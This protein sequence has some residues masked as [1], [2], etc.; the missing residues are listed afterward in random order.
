MRMRVECGSVKWEGE[1]ESATEAIKRA[2]VELPEHSS[3]LLR[4][5][6]GHGWKYLA[7]HVGLKIAGYSLI[8]TDDGH[9][10][11]KT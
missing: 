2:L 1:A 5:N 7:F 9:E 6:D 3:P 11:V 8:P 10:L 4:V